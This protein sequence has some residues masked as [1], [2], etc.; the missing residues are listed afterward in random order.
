MYA[1]FFGLHTRPFASVPSVD[2]YFPGE[3]I[4]AARQTLIR[5]I[6]RAAGVGMV[7]GPSGTGKT[8][9]CRMLA[10]HFR[11]RLKVAM[12]CSGRLS[13]RRALL[14][15]IRY[16]LGQPY[17]GMDE[18]ELRLALVDY[19]ALG[20]DCPAGMVL[21]VDEA[22]TLPYRLFEEIR[23]I[24]NLV[25]D[26]QPRVRLVLA[27]GPLLE[28]RLASPKLESFSQR[29]VA[30]CY[31]E[32]LSRGETRQYV[33][34]Q[35]DGAG[36]QGT[37]LFAEEAC[38]AVYQAT[39]GVPRLINQVCDHALLLAFAAG[40]GQVDAS[41]VEEA[42]AD[43]QQLPTPYTSE[44]GA[45]GVQGVVEF[46]GLDDAPGEPGSPPAGEPTSGQEQ[47]PAPRL[48]MAPDAEHPAPEP[49]ERLEQIEQALAEVDEDFQPAGS[50]GPEVELVFDDSVN[51]LDE[52]FQEEEIVVDR[53]VQA[54]EN[55]RA[56]PAGDPRPIPRERVGTARSHG[57]ASGQAA[58]PPAD[59]PLAAPARP[60]EGRDRT[61]EMNRS[62]SLQQPAPAGGTPPEPET[63]PMQR[64]QPDRGLPEDEDMI[65]VED[66]YED[67]QAPDAASVIPVRRQEYGQL[68]ARLRRG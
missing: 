22:H 23:M 26:G 29:L 12:L 32:P 68:F 65:V 10:E 1:A 50:I 57:D 55:A 54:P 46:G 30:R 28:E 63:V 44:T 60:A 2:Q 58:F 61:S 21:L 17:R 35:I 45:G 43:L 64:R 4:E 36:G 11:E 41:C 56:E 53:F 39:D 59:G 7:V 27:G 48:H 51:P 47:P 9:L 31:L 42:W 67:A 13:T 19:L 20:E 34:A 15:A 62:G 3:A 24:T 49:L 33:Q 25:R 16:E 38:G 66:G 37:E 6:E 18:G 14:Q 5:C 40:D 52:P 8:L